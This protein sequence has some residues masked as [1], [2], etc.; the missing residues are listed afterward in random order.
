MFY[1]CDLNGPCL[2]ITR[3]NVWTLRGKP[4]SWKI[5]TYSNLQSGLDWIGLNSKCK[6]K[7]GL[8]VYLS[9]PFLNLLHLPLQSLSLEYDFSSLGRFFFCCLFFYLIFIVFSPLFCCLCTQLFWW[10]SVHWKELVSTTD[11]LLTWQC[12]TRS[13]GAGCVSQRGPCACE[14]SFRLRRR[15]LQ[16]NGLFSV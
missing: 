6:K 2:K 12:C 15:P 16:W 8:E 1:I 10:L 9:L 11:P 4:C 14:L 13:R 5:L 3:M 7:V